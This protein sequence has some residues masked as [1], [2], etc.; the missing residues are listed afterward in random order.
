MAAFEEQLVERGFTR[1]HR[2][3][4][5][6]NAAVSAFTGTKVRIEGAELPIGRSYREA[7]S[8]ALE[9]S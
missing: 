9:A 4:L 6:R 5:I 1:I 7:V 8:E 3:Y 2:S